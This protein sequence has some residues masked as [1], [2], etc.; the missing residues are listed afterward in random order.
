VTFPLNEKLDELFQSYQRKRGEMTALQDKLRS[1]SATVT[2]D[3]GLVTVTVGAR[4]DITDLKLNTQAY[5]KMPAAQ[6]CQQIMETIQKAKKGASAQV[7]AAMKPL[8][9]AGMSFD[10]LV[11]GKFDLNDVL[12]STPI[13]FDEISRMFPSRL[14]REA[15]AG[16]DNADES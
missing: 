16:A 4:G 11:E 6:L 14:A 12:P 15:A 5:R 10:K 9:P 2:S 7:K 13:D 8:L 1:A 3:S